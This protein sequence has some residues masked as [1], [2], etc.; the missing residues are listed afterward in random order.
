MKSNTRENRTK[1][2]GNTLISRS[3]NCQSIRKW[4]CNKN[5]KNKNGKEWIDK[6]MNRG[7]GRGK[8]TLSHKRRI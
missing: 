7:K 8:I 3:R 6:G 2:E 5:N 1:E 4:K